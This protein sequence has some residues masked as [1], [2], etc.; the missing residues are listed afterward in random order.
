MPVEEVVRMTCDRCG[1]VWFPEAPAGGERPATPSLILLMKGPESDS[2]YEAS[3]DVL[4]DN[5]VKT[6]SGYS[7]GICKDLKRAKK[8]KRGAAAPPSLPPSSC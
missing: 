6:V 7:E 8:K 5:C 1:R 4:C 3:F 2:V